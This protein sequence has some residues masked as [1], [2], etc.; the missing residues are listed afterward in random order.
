MNYRTIFFA[1]LLSILAL[2]LESSPM[3][4]AADKNPKEPGATD[5]NAAKEFTTTESGLKY[6]VLRKS[7][8]E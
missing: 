7:T 6:R 5:K 3:L 8:E 1:S 4:N 2:T